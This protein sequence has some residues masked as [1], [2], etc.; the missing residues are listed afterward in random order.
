MNEVTLLGILAGTLT[1]ISFAPQA[2]KSWRT[3]RTKDVSLGMFSILCTGVALWIT[4]GVLTR[5]FPLILAN[6]VTLAL[7]FLILAMK[8]RYG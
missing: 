3:R 4:Y 2:V 5:D 6:S 7:A 8:I 1:T